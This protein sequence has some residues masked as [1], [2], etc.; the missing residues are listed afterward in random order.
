MAAVVL[1]GVFG[2]ALLVVVLI[3]LGIGLLLGL[4]L[5]RRR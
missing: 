3:I 5:G 1:A 4:A 2:K